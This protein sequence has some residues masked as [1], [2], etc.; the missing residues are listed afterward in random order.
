[1]AAT[2]RLCLSIYLYTLTMYAGPAEL[3]MIAVLVSLPLLAVIGLVL[4][5]RRA[6]RSDSPS[7]QAR[8]QELE[9]RIQE[10]ERQ[11]RR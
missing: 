3:M 6:R 8:I 4:L 9:A 5:L 7:E 10:L 11:G 2:A 1:M